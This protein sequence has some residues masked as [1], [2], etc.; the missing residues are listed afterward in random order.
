MTRFEELQ[1]IEMRA[2]YRSIREGTAE[3]RAEHE[4][5]KKNLIEYAKTLGIA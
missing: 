2:F 4:E 1:E 3:A 5:A